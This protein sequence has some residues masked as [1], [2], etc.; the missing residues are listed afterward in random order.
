MMLNTQMVETPV[1]VLKIFDQI[2]LVSDSIHDKLPGIAT[3]RISFI[4]NASSIVPNKFEKM[5]KYINIIDPKDLTRSTLDLI[6]SWLSNLRKN[7]RVMIHSN[8]PKLARMIFF[9]I[10]MDNNINLIDLVKTMNSLCSDADADPMRYPHIDI[11]YYSLTL[12]EIQLLREVEKTIRC[13]DTIGNIFDDIRSDLITE[14]DISR[15]LTSE[16]DISSDL[17]TEN[18][19]L[20]NNIND[21]SSDILPNNDSYQIDKESADLIARL[22]QEEI[23]D[24]NRLHLSSSDYVRSPIPSMTE[25]LLDP[26]PYNL[27]DY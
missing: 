13:I 8:D 14:N 12:D 15:D 24:F 4:I 9:M 20:S 1:E 7:T 26:I 11:T 25:T 22:Y 2:V 16:N 18:D 17:I 23:D 3:K 21:N 19:Q 6:K 27:Y 5:F 10:C